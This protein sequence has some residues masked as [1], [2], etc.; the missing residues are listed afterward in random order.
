MKLWFVKKMKNC[1]LLLNLNP[2]ININTL[3]NVSVFLVYFIIVELFYCLLYSK[4]LNYCTVCYTA[5]C[6]NPP[7]NSEIS[8]NCI[9]YSFSPPHPLLLLPPNVSHTRLLA[10]DETVKTIWNSEDMTIMSPALNIVSKSLIKLFWRRKKPFY[11][12]IWI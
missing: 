10:K 3:S 5:N 6:I 1:M 4:L 7:N 12:E 11:R 2:K 8:F 9:L